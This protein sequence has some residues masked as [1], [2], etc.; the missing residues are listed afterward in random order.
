MRESEIEAP[1]VKGGK[2]DTTMKET[3]TQSSSIT[4]MISKKMNWMNLVEAGI[5]LPIVEREI[6]GATVTRTEI[7]AMRDIVAGM[8][9]DM[10]EKIMN[11]VGPE[12]EALAMINGTTEKKKRTRSQTTP[13]RKKVMVS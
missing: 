4:K 12:V 2:R 3:G 13:Q 1:A 8:K 9:K 5:I 6:H 11:V 10:P 7:D